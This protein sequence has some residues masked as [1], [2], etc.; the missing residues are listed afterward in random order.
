MLYA[1]AFLHST[2]QER[3]KFGPLGWNIPYE[4]NQADFNATV[5]FIQ[6]H[7]D[8]MDVKKVL[9]CLLPPCPSAWCAWAMRLMWLLGFGIVYARKSLWRLHYF[10]I[11]SSTKN[12]TVCLWGILADY[13]Q[14]K[15]AVSGS[16][17]PRGG[18]AFLQE[19]EGKLAGNWENH[20]LR[21][22]VY[23]STAP[24]IVIQGKMAGVVGISFLYQLWN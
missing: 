13:L 22:S 21:P 15:M 19:T 16:W 7:L 9:L 17:T 2:V 10:L 4:F 18:P 8:D 14:K 24:R 5:Q 23:L 12:C 1:V 3:R 11:S 6:N 20:Q